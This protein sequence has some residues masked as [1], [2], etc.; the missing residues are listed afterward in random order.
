MNDQSNPNPEQVG[1]P[2]AQSDKLPDVA[3]TIEGAGIDMNPQTPN[4]APVIEEVSQTPVIPI[5]QDKKIE[6]KTDTQ[7]KQKKAHPTIVRMK[8]IYISS[9]EPEDTARR[10]AELREAHFEKHNIAA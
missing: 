6:H 1:E 2:I 3:G 4:Q 9:G 7:H 10:V 5:A 8:M